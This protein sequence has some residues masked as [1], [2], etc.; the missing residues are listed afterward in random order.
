[1]SEWI[2][3]CSC[4]RRILTTGQIEKKQSCEI[5]QEEHLVEFNKLRI[6]KPK[7]EDK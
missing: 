3:W 2:K 6:D 4:K 5:C 7:K 1:M